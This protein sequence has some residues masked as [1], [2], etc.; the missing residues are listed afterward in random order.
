MKGMLTKW[1]WGALAILLGLPGAYASTIGSGTDVSVLYSQ[2]QMVQGNNASVVQ[3]DVPT[4][5][6]LFLTL[7]D[8]D[9]P[10]PFA[11]LKFALTSLTSAQ[12]GLAVAGTLTLDLTAPTTLYA[13]VFW[14]A[15][16]GV[17]AGLYNLTATLLTTGDVLP[18]PL[19]ASGGLLGGVLLLALAGLARQAFTRSRRRSLQYTGNPLCVH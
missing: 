3:L 9:F 19:P 7:T 8:L 16:S 2:S 10:D 5:G 18:F 1:F 12:V 4:A 14:K 15:P 17:D 11:S 13:E 6:Q